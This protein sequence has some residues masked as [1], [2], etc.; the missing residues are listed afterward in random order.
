M[1]E[2]SDGGA[3]AEVK[4]D[5]GVGECPRRG[6]LRTYPAKRIARS[7]I[8]ALE[9]RV[10]HVEEAWGILHS[11]PDDEDDGLPSRSRQGG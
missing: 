1:A 7:R 4:S 11:D 6:R 9:A 8:A 2:L 5:D 3:I 10:A